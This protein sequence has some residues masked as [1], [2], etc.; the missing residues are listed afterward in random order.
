MQHAQAATDLSVL[1]LIRQYLLYFTSMKHFLLQLIKLI[2]GA[3]L[4]ASPWL[5]NASDNAGITI[6]NIVV[7]LLL[8]F[9]AFANFWKLMRK[10]PLVGAREE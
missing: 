8:M 6:A 9:M 5:F 2:L 3:F 4:V 1:L 7:G 10:K